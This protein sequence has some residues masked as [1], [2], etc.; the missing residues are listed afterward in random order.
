MSSN[1]YTTAARTKIL[2]Y[3]RANSN[4]SINVSD[5]HE[6]LHSVGHDVNLTT[7]Y[8]YLD[9]LTAEGSVMKYNGEKGTCAVY[10]YAKPDHRCEEHLHLKCVHCGTILHLDCGFMEEISEHIK[11]EHGFTI[12]CRNS[13]IY[14]VCERCSK[15]MGAI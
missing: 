6:Y 7:I 15:K 11:A 1:G 2:E 4:V 10:Q 13:I 8:R 9:K 12:Q 14:G 3:L 5:I